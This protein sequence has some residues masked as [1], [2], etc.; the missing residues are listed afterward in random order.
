MVHLILLF[1]LPFSVLLHWTST[2]FSFNC[3]FFII[4][5]FSVT[6]KFP[7]QGEKR[8]R[9]DISIMIKFYASMLSDKKYLAASQLVPPGEFLLSVTELLLPDCCGTE[10][11][12]T[13]VALR[14]S[15][16]KSWISLSDRDHV[17]DHF[18]TY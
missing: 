15:R 12:S 13:P 7:T 6:P 16:C 17:K 14:V 8:L 5:F 10:Y 3:F 11:Q 18:A 9:E 4:S 2:F 1:I